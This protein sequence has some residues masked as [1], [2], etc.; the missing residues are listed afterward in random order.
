MV[1]LFVLL[2][3]VRF[4]PTTTE[5]NENG[6]IEEYSMISGDSIEEIADAQIER[7]LHLMDEKE[8]FNA[9]K[10]L[11]S[12]NAT[13]NY[14][15]PM[16]G[17][18]EANLKH[19]KAKYYYA[20]GRLRLETGLEEEAIKC[21]WEGLAIAETGDLKSKLFRVLGEAC[22]RLGGV[23]KLEEFLKEK[24]LS[25]KN[26]VYTELSALYGAGNAKTL[27]GRYEEAHSVF[28]KALEIAVKNLEESDEYLIL[29]YHNLAWS[30][31]MAEDYQEA[32]KYYNKALELSLK[33][34]GKKSWLTS[35]IYFEMG[36]VYRGMGNYT[37]AIKSYLT[38]LELREKYL[39][40]DHPWTASTC[41]NLAEAF[42]EYGD[43][44]NA[45]YYA[46]KALE[47]YS[48]IY[49]ENSVETVRAY[50]R[51]SFLCRN[52][53]A[54]DEA[55]RMMKKA[56]EIVSGLSG[57]K[58]YPA[59]YV[60]GE[61]GF[62]YFYKGDYGKAI[63]FFG[64]AEKIYKELEEETT[65]L[66]RVYNGLGSSYLYLYYKGKRKND[67]KNALKYSR[68]ALEIYKKEVGEEHYYTIT[69]YMTVGQIYR[70][71]ERY[72]R[73][74]DYLQESLNLSLKTFGEQDSVTADAYAKIAATYVDMDKYKKA[75]PYYLKAVEIREKVF[76]EGHPVVTRSYMFLADIYENLGDKEQ[77]EKYREMARAAQE[78]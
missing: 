66:A 24:G 68:R 6:T 9:F 22:L 73:A 20:M 21:A 54:F 63:K 44:K 55:L 58:S 61:I 15:A 1:S 52:C 60:T 56:L 40:K 47:M 48:A 2:G 75:L 51:A 72:D 30:Y 70:V 27:R 71:M 74:L 46:K 37:A 17:E 26:L 13:L 10:T 35:K 36:S 32:L 43:C 12:V 64:K 53:G 59:A 25:G 18:D 78:D 29:A 3:E 65:D 7:A 34:L 49:G 41:M 38:S 62:I 77:A 39:G 19:V 4:Y 67:L 16:L 23:G 11:T 42:S 50:Q 8:Y 45:T 5:V 28:K 33:H 76:G 69:Q 14:L 57:A 31:Q